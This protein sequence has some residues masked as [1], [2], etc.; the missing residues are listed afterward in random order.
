MINQDRLF[1]L[2]T[3]AKRETEVDKRMRQRW[4]TLCLSVLMISHSIATHLRN[5]RHLYIDQIP[6]HIQHLRT[7]FDS[8][9]SAC[10]R[11][12]RKM[13]MAQSVRDDAAA[14]SPNIVSSIRCVSLFCLVMTVWCAI[15]NITQ[16][17]TNAND[18]KIFITIDRGLG[19]R[20]VTRTNV[21][22]RSLASHL[23]PHRKIIR[24][25]IK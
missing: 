11:T 8:I 1:L 22:V 16:R 2:S 15:V 14:S 21:S 20:N 3:A 13:Q 12:H 7:C 24:C 10:A 4:C 18:A 9:R 19:Q 23:S 5:H 6:V 25:Y 17:A